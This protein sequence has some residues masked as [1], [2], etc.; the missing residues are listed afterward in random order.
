MGIIKNLSSINK[1]QKK[2]RSAVAKFAKQ[3]S[4]AGAG[5]NA[6]KKK[7]K[8]KGASVTPAPNS[9]TL[10]NSSSNEGKSLLRKG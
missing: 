4:I 8:S 7:T 1:A 2:S 10:K 9:G 3:Y 6:V 5:S